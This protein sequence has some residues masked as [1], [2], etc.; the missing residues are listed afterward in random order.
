MIRYLACLISLIS[1]T[2]CKNP[3]SGKAASVNTTNTSSSVDTIKNKKSSLDSISCANDKTISDAGS[4]INRAFISK[5]DSSI[6]VGQ[7]KYLDHRIFGYE[8]P[9]TSSKRMIL[10]SVFSNEV[11]G[12]PFNCPLGSYYHSG[13]IEGMTLKY[14]TTEGQFV[15]VKVNKTDGPQY[16]L[17]IDKKWT[18][19]E[20]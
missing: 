4:D 15:K 7:N 19:F 6:W 8:K 2:C 17:Y 18:E 20:D 10:I 12:N 5:S 3:N 16:V 9:D 1:W 14:I 13:L 11:E